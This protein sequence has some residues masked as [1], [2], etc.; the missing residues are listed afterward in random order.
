MS[1]P[2]DSRIE[3][4][5]SFLRV[6][7]L[8]GERPAD[9]VMQEAFARGIKRATLTLARQKEGITTERRGGRWYWQRPKS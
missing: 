7:L 1:T 2:F 8:R 5:R 6:A 9:E 3:Y 4:A